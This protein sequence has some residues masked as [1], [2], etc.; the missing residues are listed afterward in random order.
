ML[1]KF[2]K[3]I[4]NLK[5]KLGSR[6]I[7]VIFF[8]I[9][10]ILALFFMITLKRFKIEKQTVQDG[11]NRSMYDFIAN[12]NNVEN[13]IAKSKIATHIKINIENILSYKWYDILYFLIF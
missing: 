2:E 5:E 1:D 9:F 7:G 3:Y 13:E 6:K 12:I 8:S 11:Y 10:C 4:N